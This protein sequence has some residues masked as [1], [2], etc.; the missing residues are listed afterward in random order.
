MPA[1]FGPAGRRGVL[2]RPPHPVHH[3]ARAG[4][5]QHRHPRLEPARGAGDRDRQHSARRS[6]TLPSGTTRR[7]TRTSSPV[8]TRNSR[9]ATRWA[10]C[11]TAAGHDL[12][13][14]MNATFG[15]NFVANGLDLKPGDE[16]IVTDQAHPGGRMGYDL[17]AKRDGIVVKVITVPTPPQSPDQLIQ[18]YLDATTPRTRVWAIPHVSSSRA[19][20]YPVAQ[21]SALARDPRYL[22]RGRRRAIARTC[23]TSICRPSAATPSSR[24]PTNGCSPPKAPGCCTCGPS[25]RRS[26]GPPSPPARGTTR[27]TRCFASCSTAPAT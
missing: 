10:P 17:R 18:L 6:A 2:A 23:R 1:E 22:E 25:G 4:L 12:A 21:L 9:A 5:L 26:S 24:R 7:A 15:M 11:S 20:R 27:P 19:I 8:T 16:V 14:T 3:P 13:L